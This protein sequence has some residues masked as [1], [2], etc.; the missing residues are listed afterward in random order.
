ML[1]KR[2]YMHENRAPGN[3]HSSAICAIVVVVA[4]VFVASPLFARAAT[5]SLRGRVT[6]ENG[7]PL[8]QSH[9][10]AKEQATGLAHPTKC[11]PDGHWIFPALPAGTYTVSASL[12]GYG[13]VTVPDV[14]VPLAGVRAIGLELV[15]TDVEEQITITVDEPIQLDRSSIGTRLDRGESGAL[16][17]GLRDVGYLSA[18]APAAAA[19]V[20]EGPLRGGGRGLELNRGEGGPA[21]VVADGASDSGALPAGLASYSIDAIEELRMELQPFDASSGPSAHGVI[22]LVTRGGS[23]DASGSVSGSLRDSSLGESTRSERRGSA[24][25]KGHESWRS[26]VALGGPIVRDRAHYFLGYD[27][28]SL[29]R[30]HV[31]DS[32][33]IDASLDGSSGVVSARERIVTVKLTATNTERQFATVRYVGQRSDDEEGANPLA[34][35]ES[36]ADVRVERDS[37]VV[38]HLWQVSPR[39][40]NE[41]SVQFVDFGSSSSSSTTAAALV[42]PGGFRQGRSPIAAQTL[43]ARTLQIDEVVSWAAVVAGSHHELRAGISFA[44]TPTQRASIATGRTGTFA[45]L[46]DVAGA[47]VRQITYSG[48]GGE[49]S[50]PVSQF[51]IF[52][53]DE[54]RVGERLSLHAGVRW[55]RASGLDLD[56]RANPIWQELA[57]QTAFDEEYLREF[58][59]GRG[60]VL[61]NDDDNWGPRF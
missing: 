26:S 21:S 56:Q 7:K 10:V 54:W 42:W 40:T 41:V 55:D 20:A 13:T 49:I 9:V 57:T 18:L 61:G 28:A 44:D 1:W 15:A 22:S 32:G 8:A 51:G 24:E 29:E 23:N 27:E 37:L 30:L 11:G 45:M 12:G 38:G 3:G 50:L 33:G 34:A 14:R 19:V 59:G 17:A 16:P 25:G 46:E 48:G 47:A 31:V 39:A 43:R 4:M 52:V 60:G 2:A 6:D 35:P 58:R 5:G 36:L 53:H